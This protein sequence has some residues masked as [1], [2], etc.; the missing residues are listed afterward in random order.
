MKA[1]RY[2]RLLLLLAVSMPIA[3]VGQTAPAQSDP[4]SSEQTPANVINCGTF[5]ASDAR[6]DLVSKLCVF[7]L[8]Y[9]RKLPDFIAEQTTTSHGARSTTVISA[10]VTFRKG[11]EHYSNVTIDGKPASADSITHSPPEFVRFT[12]SGE[13]GSL[14][15][16]LFAVP[17]AAEFKFRKMSTLQ[18]VPVA[19]YDFRVPQNKNAFWSLRDS[20]GETLKPEFRGELWLEQQTGRLLREQLEPVVLASSTGISSARLVTDYAMAA[21]GD[22]GTFLLPVKSVSTLCAAS[23]AAS[24]ACTTNVL[25]FHDYRK[26]GATTHISTSEDP[27]P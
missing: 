2:C 27:K 24:R 11:V 16:D 9:R 12:S 1:F 20:S 18:G 25:V 10:Q 21:I 23:F 7:A 13:F 6:L 19:V 26:F 8:T 17:G 3:A 15:I 14:L 22:A 4:G 5:A